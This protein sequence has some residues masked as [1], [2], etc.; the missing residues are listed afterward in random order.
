MN[1]SSLT[2]YSDWYIFFLITLIINTNQYKCLVYRYITSRIYTMEYGEDSCE[3]KRD[4]DASHYM[5][6][7]VQF[8]G[9]V[10]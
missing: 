9:D 5:L 8:K 3:E 2:K 6:L 1:H 10:C 7:Q 4:T